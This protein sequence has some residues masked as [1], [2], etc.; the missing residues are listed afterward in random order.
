M[1][2]FY[3]DSRGTQFYIHDNGVTGFVPHGNWS[4]KIIENSIKTTGEL[5]VEH[6][7]SEHRPDKTMIFTFKGVVKL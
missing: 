4:F 5:K 7:D 2:I 3:E 1:S 6:P